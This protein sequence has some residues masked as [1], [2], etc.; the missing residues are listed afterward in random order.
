VPE[1][2]YVQESSNQCIDVVKTKVQPWGYIIR[3]FTKQ[4]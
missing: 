3:D 4:A 2:N 1:N